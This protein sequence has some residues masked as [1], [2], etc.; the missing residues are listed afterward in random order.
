ML[1]MAPPLSPKRRV[2]SESQLEQKRLADRTKHKENRKVNKQALQ[3]VEHEVATIRREL[4]ALSVH[5]RRM[6]IPLLPQ[7]PMLLSETSMQHVQQQ[8]PASGRLL[9]CNCGTQ[10]LDLFGHIDH[11]GITEMYRGRT[12]Y[13]HGHDV[14]ALGDM[15]PTPSL[16]DMLLQTGH[17]SNS[18]TFFITGFMKSCP[19]KSVDQLL[20]L[21]FIAYRYMRVSQTLV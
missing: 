19:T 12:V 17:G 16:S 1:A 10:H 13:G 2:R 9:D 8:Y 6:P 3:R 4:Q 5:I 11:C 15:P 14:D 20:A 21:Y 18:A 7:P